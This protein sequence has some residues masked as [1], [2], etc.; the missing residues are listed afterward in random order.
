MAEDN[1]GSR[2][3]WWYVVIAFG[4]G[5]LMATLLLILGLVPS[6]ITVGPVSW[7]LPLPAGTQTPTDLCK[8]YGITT[9]EPQGEYTLQGAQG[10]EARITG[11]VAE[12]PPV[13]SLWL[14]TI[15]DGNPVAYWPQREV[16]IDPTTKKWNAVMYSN[17]DIYAA[18]V[19]L[20]DD[21]RIL[22]DYFWESAQL[23]V[24]KGVGYRGLT[25][26]TRDVQTCGK[27]IVRK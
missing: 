8:K 19:M 7:H 14:M 5:V 12:L 9:D 3:S 18:P 26:L 21:G 13:G 6:V 1:A 11:T 4:A 15:E 23:A 27:V 24:S 10:N 22:F 25:Q 16:S 17:N 20:G 2:V